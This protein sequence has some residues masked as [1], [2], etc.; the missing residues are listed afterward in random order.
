MSAPTTGANAAY[1]VILTI[2]LAE[3]SRAGNLSIGAKAV[4][5]S[6]T[7]FTLVTTLCRIWRVRFGSVIHRRRR[8]SRNYRVDSC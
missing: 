7:S 6:A 1:E 3:L 2:L 8:P 4:A 5:S